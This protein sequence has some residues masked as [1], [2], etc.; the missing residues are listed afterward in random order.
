[1]I[2]GAQ[3]IGS[4]LGPLTAGLMVRGDDV[5]PVPLF[6]MMSAIIGVVLLLI[7]GGVRRTRA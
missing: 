3:L 4:S 6:G 2:G 1:M 5:S 7:A